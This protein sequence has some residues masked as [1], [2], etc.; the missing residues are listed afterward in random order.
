MNNGCRLGLFDSQDT[1]AP[2]FASLDLSCCVWDLCFWWR[3]WFLMCK[4]LGRVCY[5]WGT[6][7]ETPSVV[8][9]S[10]SFLLRLS[11][12]QHCIVNEEG[13]S[14]SYNKLR[15][16]S[17][18]HLN[19]V[20][21]LFGGEAAFVRTI[22]AYIRA[23]IYHSLSIELQLISHTTTLR[24]LTSS[25]NG[26]NEFSASWRFTVTMKFNIVGR[27]IS[28]RHIYI[29]W[30]IEACSHVMWKGVRIQPQCV[31]ET[32]KHLI[33]GHLHCLKSTEL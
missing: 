33:V 4:A 25:S 17:L 23:L 10:P 30:S 18:V 28:A 27:G 26:S 13:K 21:S 8:R 9:S 24:S 29:L 2:F 15:F 6:W 14:W 1:Q 19:D 32:W 11:R 5:V 7:F 20:K 22:A 31:R 3:E 16:R 12:F